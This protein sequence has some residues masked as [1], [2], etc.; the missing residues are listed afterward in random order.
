VIEVAGSDA[1]GV[2]SRPLIP[3]GRKLKPESFRTSFLEEHPG[4]DDML[5]DKDES[6]E[7]E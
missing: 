7:D 1:T 4:T 5:A 3:E 2:F 6:L